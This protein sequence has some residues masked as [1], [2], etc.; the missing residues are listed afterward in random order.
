MVSMFIVRGIKYRSKFNTA[1]LVSDAC[2]VCIF[3]SIP[4]F[5]ATAE[6]IAVEFIA[7]VSVR[8]LGE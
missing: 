6:F 3:P 8:S 1:W 2:R 7:I 4:I 5:A